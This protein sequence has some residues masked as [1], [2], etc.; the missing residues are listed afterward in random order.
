MTQ[1]FA[2]K[3]LIALTLLVSTIAGYTT[4]RWRQEVVREKRI[5]DFY[6]DVETKRK[7]DKAL[8]DRFDNWGD[9]LKKHR[10]Q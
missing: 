2:I 6:K 10:I 7:E 4:Y 1:L 9:G 5:E 3:L 8:L